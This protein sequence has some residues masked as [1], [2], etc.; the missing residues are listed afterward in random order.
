MAEPKLLDRMRA[1]LR[2]RHYSIRTEDAYVQWARRFILTREEVGRLLGAM[3]GTAQLV[4]R[5]LY[6]TGMRLLECLR[7]RVK[8]ADFQSGEVLVRTGKENKDRKTMLPRVLC[9]ALRHH[10]ENVRVLH[11]RDV[12]VGFGRVWMPE[13][14]AVKHPNA[15][16]SWGG[17]GFFLPRSEAS[18]RGVESCG[19]II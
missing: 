7:L 9:V 14:L 12:A 17:S 1:L 5:F 3:N 11:D 8:D 18:T 10:M 15:N 13:A 19:D 16:G 4:A 2:T 6:G